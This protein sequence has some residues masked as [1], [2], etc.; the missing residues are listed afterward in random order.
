MSSTRNRIY[1]WGLVVVLAAA[2]I[3]SAGFLTGR[4]S[5]QAHAYGNLTVFSAEG[6]IANFWQSMALRIAP[7]KYNNKPMLPLA[8]RIA[9]F[10]YQSKPML[11]LALRIAPFKYQ[12]KPM[13]PLAL[14][15]A[16]FK[17]QSKPMLPLALRIAPFKYQSK[18]MLP[19]I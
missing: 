16:P 1:N 5:G 8:L 10:K 13:L 7:F 18:P 4:V 15:I 3:L 6:R 17:Y 19:L 11:P 14:R 9:P 12:T 2:F